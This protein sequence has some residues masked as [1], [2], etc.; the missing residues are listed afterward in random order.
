MCQA[1]RFFAP[2]LAQAAIVLNSEN[3]CSINTYIAL[4]HEHLM[5]KA[6]I[7]VSIESDSAIF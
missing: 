4:V 1:S 7:L 2:V 3:L 6:D 5:K